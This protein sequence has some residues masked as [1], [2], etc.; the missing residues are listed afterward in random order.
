MF[1]HYHTHTFTFT[2]PSSPQDGLNVEFIMKRA[3]L[4]H[5]INSKQQ[6]TKLH[7]IGKHMINNAEKKH[8]IVQSIICII[9]E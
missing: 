1:S 5:A 3:E 6:V 4:Q 2:D 8:T 7:K 9:K